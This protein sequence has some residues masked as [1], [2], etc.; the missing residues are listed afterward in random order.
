LINFDTGDQTPI[1]KTF[2]LESMQSKANKQTKT[3]KV[4]E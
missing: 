4:D 3:E 2:K 1:D